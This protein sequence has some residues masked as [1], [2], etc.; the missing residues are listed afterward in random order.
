MKNVMDKIAERARKKEREQNREGG[1][2]EGNLGGQSDAFLLRNFDPEEWSDMSFSDASEGAS[3]A[4]FFRPDFTASD[5]LPTLTRMVPGWSLTTDNAV[6][7]VKPQLAV[8]PL[9]RRAS[10]R[11]VRRNG[12]AQPR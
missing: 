9:L 10:A 6:P 1:E 7:L 5:E 2:G 8:S 3:T 12:D 4:S 11:N